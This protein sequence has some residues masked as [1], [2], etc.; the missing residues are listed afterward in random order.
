MSKNI[1]TNANIAQIILS[2]KHEI[3]LKKKPKKKSSNRKKEALEKVKEALQQ[4]DTAINSAKAA[5]IQIPEA[6]G[7]LPDNIN[8]INS[9]KELE[10]LALDLQNRVSQINALLAQGAK[11]TTGLFREISGPQQAGFI[12]VAQQVQPRIIP[13]QQFPQQPIQPLTPPQPIT[14]TQQEDD[15]AEKTLDEL[16]KEILSKLS[17]EDK[18][19]AEAEFEKERQERQEEF[20]KERAG[21]IRKPTDPV[22]PSQPALTPPTPDEP[23]SSDSDIVESKGLEKVL[24]NERFDI[25]A[26]RGW[27]NIYSEYRILIKNLLADII[28][29]DDK[30]LNLPKAKNREI[31]NQQKNI[32]DDYDKWLNSLNENQKKFYD[33]NPQ[34][35]QLDNTMIRD[36]QISPVQLLTEIAKAQKLDVTITSGEASKREQEE[37]KLLSPRAKEFLMFLKQNQGSINGV[38]KKAS[39]KTLQTDFD[40]QLQ[41]Y[42]DYITDLNKFSQNIQ[43]EF[44]S[45]AGTDKVGILSTYNKTQ[46]GL[47]QAI[48]EISDAKR[49]FEDNTTVLTI[50]PIDFEA[51]VEVGKIMPLPRPKP[52]LT[53]QQEKYKKLQEELKKLPDPFTPIEPAGVG[54]PTDNLD[55]QNV[56]ILIDYYKN[57]SVNFARKQKNSYLELFGQDKLSKIQLKKG[58]K[59]KLPVIKR[60]IQTKF[61]KVPDSQFMTVASQ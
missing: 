40:V 17:P 46:D 50:P 48:V 6:L 47:Q 24:S 33:T 29:I 18:A 61:P 45:L 15:D 25:K 1:N 43:A 11:R 59:L 8:Q 22:D 60:E 3:R 9:V 4:F 41:K 52:K 21:D 36:L 39:D 35:Q 53:P 19:K 38:L 5:N 26:P 16:Q 34:I 20:D 12:P 42:D 56:D 27:A 23:T 32:L 51:P 30:T 54:L 2:D 14:P 10:A 37:S 44:D 49:Y 57:P 13:N 31:M 58:R 7:K 55:K 28:K